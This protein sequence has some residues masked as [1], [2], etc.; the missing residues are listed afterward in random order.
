M[1]SPRG[2]IHDEKLAEWAKAIGQCIQSGKPVSQW[3]K[4][5][6]VRSSKYYYWQNRVYGTMESLGMALGPS[7]PIAI[8]DS[9]AAI[10]S[11]TGAMAGL[12]RV[13]LRKP[14]AAIADGEGAS[15]TNVPSVPVPAM[16]VSIGAA[17]CEIYNGADASTIDRALAALA[18]ACLAT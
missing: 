13:D 11:V 9:A 14:S 8:G 15:P 12:V 3:C 1:V 17:R 18:K 4:E 16:G 5:N 6:G 10:P 2:T 7:V